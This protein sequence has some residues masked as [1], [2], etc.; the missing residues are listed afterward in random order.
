MKRTGRRL[1]SL[2]IPALGL[3]LAAT[4]RA[5]AFQAGG[6]GKTPAAR[7]G[8]PEAREAQPPGTGARQ[9][10]GPSRVMAGELITVTAQVEKVDKRKR[11]IRLRDEAGNEH[12]IKVPEDMKAF[13]QI[14]RG[15]RITVRYWESLAARL[16]PAGNLPTDFQQ[17]TVMGPHGM[18]RQMTAVTKITSVD[19][20]NNTLTVE[21]PAGER[22]TIKVKDRAMQQRL[23]QLKP[24]ENVEVTY[25]E[26][27][28]ASLKRAAGK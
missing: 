4:P 6:E 7:E 18:M 23:P 10:P 14:K 11:T 26:A 3:L 28:A 22:H 8:Q 25:T 27:L 2:G 17:R 19:A 21:G 12:T 5:N 13:D 9:Q 20:Q 1:L 24:G 16:R 15:D